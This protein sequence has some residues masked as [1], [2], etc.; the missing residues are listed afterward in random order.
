MRAQSSLQPTTIGLGT[1]VAFGGVMA[2]AVCLVGDVYGP[3]RRLMRDALVDAGYEVL[4][5]DSSTALATQA[6]EPA[7]VLA[8]TLLIVLSGKWATQCAVPL[9]VAATMRHQLSLAPVCVA[10]LY[11]LGTLGVVESPE[12]H[13]CRTLAMLEKPF[14]MDLL[15]E[16]ARAARAGVQPFDEAPQ[17]WQLFPP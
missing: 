8:P 13:H 2:E 15:R 6:H 9:S 7:V 3:L 5:A 4:E 17:G 14:E 11:E 10:L 1:C 16:I 12:L